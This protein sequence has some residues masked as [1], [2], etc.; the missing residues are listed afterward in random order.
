MN[1]IREAIK[2]PNGVLL[3]VLIALVTLGSFYVK[4]GDAVDL[5]VGRSKPVQELQVQAAS[6]KQMT[7]DILDKITDVKDDVKSIHS[8]VHKILERVKR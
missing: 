4:I 3:A 2:S 6:Q 7:Q 1:Q 8:D 5:I